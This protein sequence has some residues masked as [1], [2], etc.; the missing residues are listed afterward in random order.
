MKILSATVRNYRIHREC[1]ISFDDARTLIGGLNET[2]KSTLV[3]AI[4]RALFLKSKGTSALHKAMVST[5]YAGHPEVELV[6]AV[7]DNEYMLRKRFSGQNGTTQLTQ[8]GGDTWQGDEAE[9]QLATLLGNEDAGGRTTVSRI[10][11]HWAHLWVWQG[12]SG[13]DPSE[14]A[15]SQQSQLFQQLQDSGG[16]VA[17]QS[18]LDGKVAAFFA[19]TRDEIFV[20]AGGARAGSEL[21]NAGTEFQLAQAAHAGA[22]ERLGKLQQAITDF[23]AA[24]NTIERT[25]INRKELREQQAALSDTMSQAEELKRT[26]QDQTVAAEGA[27]ERV[28]TLKG[29]ETSIS[30]L[31]NSVAAAKKSLGPKQGKKENAERGLS[32]ARTQ[33]SDAV[34]AYEEALTKTRTVRLR[35]DF[36]S[37]YIA[38][39]EKDTRNQELEARSERVQAIQKKSEEHRNQLAQLPAVDQEGLDAIRDV[40]NRLAQATAALNAMAAEIEV[41]SAD[42]PV[43]VG[44]DELDVGGSR[45]VSE[46]TDIQVGESLRL[47]LYPGGGDSLSEA[48]DQVGTLQGQLQQ[49]LDAYGVDSIARIAEV[50]A[51][52]GDLQTKLDTAETTLEEL[53][54]DE[55]REACTEA[56]TELTAAQSDVSRRQEQVT[57]VDL[58]SKMVEAKA[59][60]EEEDAALQTAESDE[61]GLKATRDSAQD[62]VTGLDSELRDLA[63]T[64][65]E[66]R[67]ALTGFE[68]QFK[69]LVDS[70]GDDEARRNALEDA[71]KTQTDT[72]AALT[73]TCAALGAL[74][75]DLLEADRQRLER[76][77]EEEQRQQQEA[78]TTRAV[79]QTILRSD[80]TEDPVAARA[81]TDARLASAQGDLDAVSRKAKA[82]ALID[83]LFQQEQRALADRFSRPLAEKVSGYLQTLFG[84]DAQA[85]VA[86]E[87]NALTGIQLVRSAQDGAFPFE[88]LSGGTREQVAAAV[89]LAI[90][91]L[92]AADH[93]G[94]LPVIFDDAFVYSDPERVHV[95]QRMLDL[96]AT[97]GLQIIVLTCN[98][99]DYAALGASQVN[100]TPEPTQDRTTARSAGI[101]ER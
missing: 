75:P 39:L 33:A 55:L 70:H 34:H 16:S 48:R 65:I 56:K 47:R 80:G 17:M 30:G 64:I 67:Q 71:E 101:S 52:R 54:A 89:R 37:A 69:L 76:A 3:E 85:V 31:G 7:G 60:R 4:H 15:A 90:A 1:S 20:R 72:E 66:E 53:G 91:E 2:G 26:E 51:L 22:E 99:S 23:E 10:N 8:Y 95:L 87:D 74:Q 59:W 57:G 97:R 42:G 43:L 9:E 36:A 78:Q 86:F 100:L 92:L 12:V 40:E 28:T 27:A 5:L 25:E 83:E 50:V 82:I 62:L 94:T 32:G 77:L 19:R 46:S 29:I 58:P 49:S 41:V 63:E 11:E 14:H 38:L 96:G 24:K 21:D 79:S 61:A 88:D 73:Q 13:D 18:E 84:S 35:R 6:F 93:G 98:P 68:A 44:G 81:Q 45:T